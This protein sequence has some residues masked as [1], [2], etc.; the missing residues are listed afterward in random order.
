MM[1]MAGVLSAADNTGVKITELE[2][3]VRV[4]I[5]G[6]LFTEYHFKGAPHVYF[7]P[8]IG[9][10]KLPMTRNFPMKEVE[11][12]ER[13]SPSVREV[14]RAAVRARGDTVGGGEAVDPWRD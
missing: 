9:P 13:E 12:E 5:N 4:E 2:N 10:G 1:L 7:Y 11:G 6:E 8:V 3:K 14:E